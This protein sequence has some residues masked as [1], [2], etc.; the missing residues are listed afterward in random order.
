M[1][2]AMRIISFICQSKTIKNNQ[3]YVKNEV[4]GRGSGNS[5][6][7]LIYSAPHPNIQKQQKN[8]ISFGFLKPFFKNNPEKNV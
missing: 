7:L 3:F 5:V 2:L 1:Q 6:L 8:P 4:R